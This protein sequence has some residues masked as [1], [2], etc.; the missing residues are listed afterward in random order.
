MATGLHIRNGITLDKFTNQFSSS[1]ALSYDPTTGQIGYMGTGSF[2][3]GY[4]TLDNTGS[5]IVTGSSGTTQTIKGNLTINENL[6]VLGT[7]SIQYLNVIYETAS[8]IYSSGSNQFG[9]ATNDTQTL[10]G[11][12]RVSGSQ[13]ITGSLD[14]SNIQYASTS[15]LLAWNSTTG[16]I[17]YMSGADIVVFPYTGSAIMSGSSATGNTLNVIGTL[18]VTGSLG[19]TGS[20]YIGSKATNNLLIT[21]AAGSGYLQGNAITV[22]GPDGGPASPNIILHSNTTDI[23]G[24]RIEMARSYANN[25]LAAGNDMGELRFWRAYG[26]LSFTQGAYIKASVISGSN[27][28]SGPGALYFGTT[29]SGSITPQQRLVIQENGNIGIGAVTASATLHV[30]G[31]NMI[32]DIPSK[33]NG[34][35]LQSDANGTATW[36]NPTTLTTANPTQM[37]TGSITASVNIGSPDIF[38]IV[39]G[40]ST[41]L[42]ITGSTRHLSVSGGIALHAGIPYAST[43][44]GGIDG[45]IQTFVVPSTYKTQMVFRPSGN[46]GG[47]ASFWYSR[48]EQDGNRFKMLS[49][50]PQNCIGHIDNNGGTNVIGYKDGVSGNH[51]LV[52]SSNATSVVTTNY[53]SLLVTGSGITGDIFKVN[54]SQDF[55][56]VNS[57]G[58]TTVSGS[59][60]FSGSA[61]SLQFNLP[62]KASGY[63]LQSDTNGYASWVSPG[64]VAVFPYTG[65]ALISG[66]LIV[67]GSINVNG[68]ITGSLQGTAS[69][70]SN[71]DLFD[72]KDSSTFATTGSN[73]YIGNQN[74]TGSLGINGSLTEYIVTSSLASGVTTVFQRETGSFTSALAKYTINKSTNAR[75]GEFMTVWNGN[76]IVNADISTTDIGSTAEVAFSSSLVNG[77]IQTNIVTGTPGWT[78]KML[79]TYL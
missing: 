65:S 78:A 3:T 32:F 22:Q 30:S 49:Q 64:S 19:I 75:A 38:K 61:G 6:T 53:G 60:V 77:Q 59:L 69:Y 52:V 15:N 27:V 34:Y 36:V 66:S 79:I 40:S 23:I 37:A 57:N 9:D 56:I 28:T 50:Y 7:A 70:A 5:F 12:V 72:G 41:L 18:A 58:I 4:L 16:R 45:V 62:S 46:L 24:P 8:V 31:A 47:F 2:S 68:S 44:G 67:T 33:A 1:Y 55:F 43:F 17:S 10:I 54:K 42:S 76:E 21:S 29:P 71:S 26:T 39:S 48:L 11:T 14:V 74:V 63:V 13:V 73:T 35:V 20:V 51:G 25:N